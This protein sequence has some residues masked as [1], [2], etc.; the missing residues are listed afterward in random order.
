MRQ[1]KRG[2]DGRF[3]EENTDNVCFAMGGI[4]TILR[5]ARHA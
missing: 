5:S 3:V 4:R 1:K 2:G